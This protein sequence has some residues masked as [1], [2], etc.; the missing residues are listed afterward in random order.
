MKFLQIPVFLA[1]LTTFALGNEQGCLTSVDD[2]VDYFPNKVSPEESSHWSIEYYN[3]YKILTDTNAGTSYLL[4]QCGS[5]PPT[6][7]GNYTAVISV[8]VEEVG[9]SAT[10][11]I[12]F[13]ELLGAR[14]KIKATLG[15]YTASSVSSPCALELLDSG[16][17]VDIASPSNSSTF[18][19]ISPD[20]PVFVGVVGSTAFETE[21]TISVYEEDENLAMFEWIKYY[22]ALFNLE[23]TANEIWD[24]T[25]GIYTCAEENADVIAAESD[26]TPVVLWGYYSS[27]AGAWS[28]AE[29]PNYYCEFAEACQAEILHSTEGSVELYG[30]NYMTTEEFVAFGKDA[31]V[32]VFPSSGFEDTLTMFAAELADFKSVQNQQVYDNQGSG[33]SAW[34]EQRLAEPD[35]IL[36]DFC[37]IVGHDNEALETP[38]VR[39]WLRDVYTEAIG[40]LD[41]AC[42]D[43]EA[44]YVPRHTECFP[45]GPTSAPTSAPTVATTEGSTTTA[46]TASSAAK[47]GVFFALAAVAMAFV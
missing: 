14:T 22:S 16:E 20:L 3:T 37:Q 8:P 45:L 34:F 2:A 39:S 10:T 1:G 44:P 35:V 18:E 4:Y 26:I 42:T 47:T 23:E 15:A 6:M 30:A 19:D 7:S 31:D 29:C 40:G 13:V 27:W 46:P 21:V 28:V 33:I 32:W 41:A 17:I 5:E 38:H 25:S 11:Q 36:Q 43:V 12:P 24:E 9:V